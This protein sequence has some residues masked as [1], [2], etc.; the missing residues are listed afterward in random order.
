MKTYRETE[1]RRAGAMGGGESM[2]LSLS[3]HLALLQIKL[4]YV[5]LRM[6][7]EL[8]SFIICM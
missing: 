3:K 1:N 2:P 8:S 4:V 6:A 5:V 7:A